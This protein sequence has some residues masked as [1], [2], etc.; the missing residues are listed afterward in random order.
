M[1]CSCLRR[2]RE[3]RRKTRIFWTI[4]CTKKWGSRNRGSNIDFLYLNHLPRIRSKNRPLLAMGTQIEFATP[5]TSRL[6]TEPLS[7]IR[8]P[9][10]E[11]MNSSVFSALPWSRR[12]AKKVSTL[13]DT[14]LHRAAWAVA[15]RQFPTHGIVFLAFIAIVGIGAAQKLWS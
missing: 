12:S 10:S 7:K 15:G 11:N 5:G 4:L 8:R 14:S 2:R 3:S 9:N 13:L 1:P 6:Q